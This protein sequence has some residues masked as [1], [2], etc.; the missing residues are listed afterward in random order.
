MLRGGMG[1]PWVLQNGQE[2][3]S[4][5]EALGLEVGMGNEARVVQ[6]DLGL[7]GRGYLSHFFL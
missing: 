7:L 4:R 5:E 6:G 1:T 2:F 3:R